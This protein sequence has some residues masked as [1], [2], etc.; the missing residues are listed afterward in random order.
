MHNLAQVSRD[1]NLLKELARSS[2]QSWQRLLAREAPAKMPERD[3]PADF[4]FPYVIGRPTPYECCDAKG[5]EISAD[6]GV[7]RTNQVVWLEHPL[8]DGK[9]ARSVVAFLPSAG[10]ILLDAR[11]LIVAH[12]APIQPAA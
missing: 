5:R 3:P 11:G 6:G 1:R 10:L 9:P 8:R 12:R 2:E 4:H 7:V